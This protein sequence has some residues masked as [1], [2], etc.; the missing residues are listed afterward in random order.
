MYR[1]IIYVYVLIYITLTYE[2]FA[3]QLFLS[4]NELSKITACI[5]T[6]KR[7]EIQNDVAYIHTHDSNNIAFSKLNKGRY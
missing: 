4:N 6:Y 2:T 5:Y 1:N 7:Q 3:V